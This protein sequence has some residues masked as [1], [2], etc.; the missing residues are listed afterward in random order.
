MIGAMQSK[1]V[2]V[3]GCVAALAAA[4]A[5]GRPSVEYWVSSAG[6]DNGDASSS[7]PVKTVAR[8]L[9]LSRLQMSDARKI[10]V[11]KDGVY[12]IEKP[13][14]VEKTDGDIVVK[15]EHSRKAT[16]TGSKKL[17]GWK[18]DPKDKRFL[19]C[20]L[21]FE[22]VPDAE[23]T[24]TSGVEFRPLAEHWAKIPMPKT[25]PN[26]FTYMPYDR[27]SF[28]KDMDFDGLDL[29]SVYV[30]VLQEWATTKSLIATNDVAGKSFWLATK[31]NMAIGNYNQGFRL[32][33]ARVG[34]T[35]P[36]MWMYEKGEK[37]VM[38]WPTEGETAENLKCEISFAPAIFDVK[39][40]CRGVEI[41]GFVI[42]GCAKWKFTGYA[43]GN[44]PMYAAVSLK[45]PNRCKVS[46]LEVRNCA[47]DGISIFKADWSTVENCLVHNVGATCINVCGG[48]SH[49]KVVGNHVHHG[50]QINQS[51][52]LVG[53]Q[54][55][56]GD[57]VGNKIHDVP[58]CGITMWGIRNNVISNEIADCMSRQR[59]GGGLYGAYDYS[60]VK[61]NWCHNRKDPGWPSLYADEGSRH[62]VFTGNR[63]EGNSWPLHLHQC[64]NI[65]VTNNTFTHVKPMRWTFQGSV[66]DIFAE[67]KIYAAQDVTNDAYVA[68]CDRWADNEIYVKGADGEYFLKRKLT[69]VNA[70]TDMIPSGGVVTVPRIDKPVIVNGDNWPFWQYPI[71]WRE[72]M[73]AGRDLFGRESGGTPFQLVKFS[74]D[75]KHLNL[76]VQMWYSAFT[77]YDGRLNPGNEWG[78]HDGLKLYVGTDLVVTMMSGGKVEWNDKDLKLTEED[79]EVKYFDWRRTGYEVRI[80]L[81]YLG[82]KHADDAEGKEIAFNAVTFVRDHDEFKVLF[83]PVNGKLAAGGKLKFGKLYKEEAK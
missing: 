24:F 51:A 45:W 36:G 60:L 64:R 52:P 4:S 20:P 48:G 32:V 2:L 1:K 76:N 22:P 26:N 80:P 63:I 44:D 42:E 33:N 72:T 5:F 6:D 8:A 31:A 65:V 78:H 57:L 21:P 40:N 28:P 16:L 11:V 29:T 23:H 68:G 30:L 82:F 27:G 14:V 55:Y 38:Y 71:Q 50:G 53:F 17:T 19:T 15:A 62:T 49:D 83:V 18:A 9:E 13:I 61:D 67:N 47:A 56:A 70:P 58:G 69:L 73:R 66:N 74:Y 35:A 77:V 43:N 54:T 46:D 10:V 75:D 41:S 39:S 34:M 79:Y 59:D 3:A 37:R 25:D 7:K 81:E 12:E